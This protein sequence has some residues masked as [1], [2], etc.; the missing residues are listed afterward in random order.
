MKST[1]TRPC[2]GACD[3]RRFSVCAISWTGFT[4][5][6]RRVSNRALLFGLSIWFVAVVGGFA[7]L[8]RYSYTSGD[9][10]EPPPD[11]NL[12]DLQLPAAAGKYQLVMAVHPKCP[13]TRSSI[14]E[15]HRIIT[16][17]RGRIVCSF[18]IFEPADVPAGWSET[19]TVVAA[20]RL[21]GATLIPDPVGRF[22]GRLGMK[23]S[24]SVVFLDPDGTPVFH[25]G[26]TPARNHE[27]NNLGADA[28]ISFVRHGTAARNY[29]PVY[30]CS[31]ASSACTD[32]ERCRETKRSLPE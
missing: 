28:V 9:V 17:C 31:I 32:H 6:I 11:F 24:G 29:A 22:A 4:R 25:G 27:G 2:D 1:D 21:P 30:G 14:F 8:T 7:L 19:G 20:S 13:C 5:S 16:K 18:F 3:A 23:T 15:L 26:I 10:T 12:A